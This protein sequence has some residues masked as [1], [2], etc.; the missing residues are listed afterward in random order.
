MWLSTKDLFIGP[1][2]ILLQLIP[3]SFRL[4]FPPLYRI[5]STFHVSLLKLLIPGLLDDV[6][7][8][9]VS[10]EE[11]DI[12]GQPAY[13]IED[14]LRSWCWAGQIEYLID[15]EGYGPEEQRW[16]PAKDILDPLI[17]LNFY[18]RNPNQWG[19]QT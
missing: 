4:E 1:F 15:W 14:I 19:T 18:R 8:P 5:N 11:P 17:T 3:V 7:R 13:I 2:K 10:Q 12:D 16:V 9:E 6:S